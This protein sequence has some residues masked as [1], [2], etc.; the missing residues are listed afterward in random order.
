M[1]RDHVAPGGAPVRPVVSRLFEL[2]RAA[3][4][5]P[6]AEERVLEDL[7]ARLSLFDEAPS[8]TPVPS[9]PAP[10]EERQPGPD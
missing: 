10:P 3:P 9:T 8:G 6:G 5:L 1:R 7:A 4:D 2:M